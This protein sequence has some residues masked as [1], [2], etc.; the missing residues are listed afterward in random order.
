MNK[1]IEPV[2][3]YRSQSGAMF[4]TEEEARKNNQLYGLNRLAAS[5]RHG[6]YPNWIILNYEAIKA[7]ME[8]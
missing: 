6:I 2:I 1:P 4:A 8:S 7:I 3:G 5:A